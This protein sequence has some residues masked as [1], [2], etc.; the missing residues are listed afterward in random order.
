MPDNQRSPKTNSGGPPFRPIYEPLYAKLTPEQNSSKI[1]YGMGSL[2]LKHAAE[3]LRKL[4]LLMF[5]KYQLIE[6]FDQQLAESWSGPS[7]KRMAETI[8]EFKQWLDTFWQDIQ[9]VAIRSTYLAKAFDDASDAIPDNT[10]I[11]LNRE[12]RKE[13]ARR[14]GEGLARYD[15]EIAA[16][17]REYEEFWA[18]AVAAM[19]TYEV[20]ARAVLAGMPS[21][22][23]P[24]RADAEWGAELRQ[25]GG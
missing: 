9:K 24:P 5:E 16:L 6:K 1:H 25:R 20:T 19:S 8:G 2:S 7:A 4:T 10:T 3:A 11:F 23:E 15:A 14:Q 12:K 21:W 17:D 13:M 18:S 22:K